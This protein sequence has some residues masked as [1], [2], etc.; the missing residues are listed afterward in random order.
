MVESCSRYWY[1]GVLGFSGAILSPCG[2]I[3]AFYRESYDGSGFEEFPFRIEVDPPCLE[4]PF[5]D[6]G[7]PPC[8]VYRLDK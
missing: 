5:E 7:A 2:C 4:F 6:G 1:C 3:F 8:V